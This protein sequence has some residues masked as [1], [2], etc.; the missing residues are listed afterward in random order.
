[1]SADIARHASC[2]LSSHLSF[3]V[4]TSSESREPP[5]AP[6][7]TQQFIYDRN[8]FIRI[9]DVDP[10]S[11]LVQTDEM[12]NN[13]FDEAVCRVEARVDDRQLAAAV[14]QQR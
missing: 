3:G 5:E 13:S 9:S 7:A 14:Y 11:N 2:F 6:V 1:M 4:W 8:M 10:G 12:A